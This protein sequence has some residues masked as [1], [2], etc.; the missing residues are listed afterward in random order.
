MVFDVHSD[1]VLTNIE[2]FIA[3]RPPLAQKEFRDNPFQSIISQDLVIV[4]GMNFSPL[5]PEESKSQQKSNL[6]F[7]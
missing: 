4:S 2:D 1:L 6:I 5:P 7:R 3:K